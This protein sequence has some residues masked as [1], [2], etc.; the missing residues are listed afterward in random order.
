MHNS[1]YCIFLIQ[2]IYHRSELWN[3]DIHVVYTC[4]IVVY[5]R[6]ASTGGSPWICDEMVQYYNGGKFGVLRVAFYI[7]FAEFPIFAE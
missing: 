1:G 7:A 3:S 5:P 2:Y 6:Q 4:C